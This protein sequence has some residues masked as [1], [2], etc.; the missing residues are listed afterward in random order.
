LAY[1]YQ[2]LVY[3]WLTYENNFKGKNLNITVNEKPAIIQSNEFSIR[4]PRIGAQSNIVA[5]VSPYNPDEYLKVL[6][7]NLIAQ[8]KTSSTPGNGKGTMTYL[9]AHSS[10]QSLQMVRNNSVFYLL[11]ELG[12]DDVIIINYKGTNYVYKIYMKKVVNASDVFYLNYIDKEK[13]I[14]ILQTCW[15]IGTNWK[16]LLVFAERV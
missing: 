12:N 15:P 13:E 9:F 11:G 8:S 1:L 5:N 10:Q 4:I 6:A 3:S 16:R 2:P 14:V 7:D